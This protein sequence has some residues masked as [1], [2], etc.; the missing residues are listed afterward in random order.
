MRHQSEV[1][2]F[3]ADLTERAVKSTIGALGSFLLSDEVARLVSLTLQER[4]AVWALGSTVISVA[5]SLLSRHIGTPG[6]ASVTRKVTY[7]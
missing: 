2:P 3:G 4:A 5:L 7:D 1:S 6:T